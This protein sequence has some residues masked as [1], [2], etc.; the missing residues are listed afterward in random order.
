[1]NRSFVHARAIAD[2]LAPRLTPRIL[3]PIV[4]LLAVI[5]GLTAGRVM[6]SRGDDDRLVI[7]NTA[8]TLSAVLQLHNTRIAI[9]GGNSYADLTDFVDRSTLPWKRQVGLLVIP[10]WDGRHVAGALGLVERGPVDGIAVIGT[11]GSE[12]EWGIMEE[13]ARR[14]GASIRYLAGE[15]R[16]TI[17]DG[18]TFTFEASPSGDQTDTGA[19]TITLNYHGAKFVFVDAATA[20][21]KA[22]NRVTN[23]VDTTRILVSL[24]SPAELAAQGARVAIRPVARRSSDLAVTGADY[25][26]DLTTGSRL[27]IRLRPG[28]VRI[29]ENRL[30][31]AVHP[32]STEEATRLRSSPEAMSPG[33][34]TGAF[35]L[36]RLDGMREPSKHA[37][38]EGII[39]SRNIPLW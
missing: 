1:M 23:G 20:N 33:N 11:R 35:P 7:G 24:R 10:G 29:P 13:A 9:G 4:L 30:S 31:K 17:E 18:V 26:G 6:A 32:Q 28:E 38:R 36:L 12:P 25:T 16:L 22:W 15:H 39:P 19:A 8:G 5:G 2:R 37:V 21:E 27:T 34:F 3:I 14:S